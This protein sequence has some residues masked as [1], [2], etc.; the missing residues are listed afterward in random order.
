MSAYQA[1]DETAIAWSRTIG[2][3]VAGPDINTCVVPK[4]VSMSWWFGAVGQYSRA[5]S[6]AAR[7][8]RRAASLRN[9][10]S[11]RDFLF[12]SGTGPVSHPHKLP[13]QAA[14]VEHRNIYSY[15]LLTT[16]V[17]VPRASLQG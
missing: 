3:P 2:V 1:G 15:V 10:P 13:G 17:I 11:L 6:Y 5:A 8:R 14:A 12:V 7:N 16:A 9:R 4:V